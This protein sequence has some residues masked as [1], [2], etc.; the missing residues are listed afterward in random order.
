MHYTYSMANSQDKSSSGK[1]S[2]HIGH[3]DINASSFES[4]PAT[5]GLP[6]LVTRN[7]V[8]FPG[9]SLPLVLVRDESLFLAREAERLHIP[10]GV[11]NQL[12][13]DNEEVNSISEVFDYGVFAHVL[14]VLE[15]PDDT[16][17]ALLKAGTR[18][19]ITG[20]GNKEVIPMAALHAHVV[21]ATET[22]SHDQ[23]MM[24][25]LA[26]NI[27]DC[28]Q[29]I[30]EA[31]SNDGAEF[32]SNLDNYT[33]PDEIINFVCTTAPVDIEDKRELL[34]RR[35]LMKRGTQLL[36]LLQ[37]LQSQH[38]MRRELFE[39]TKTEMDAHQREAFLR[40]EMELISNQLYGDADDLGQ[41]QK[42]LEES[43]LPDSIRKSLEREMTRLKRFNPQSPDF[44]VLYGYIETVLDIPWNKASETI[45][46]YNT[47]AEVLEADHY[48]LTKVKERILE[49][50]AV[51]VN[52]PDGRAPI[53]CL[54]GPPGVGKTSLGRSVARAL[55]REYA[56]VSLGGLHDE[57]EIRGH[58]RTYIGA[59]PGR[60]I[61]AL[62]K[63]GTNNPVIVLDEIDKIGKDYK[64]DPDAAL[65]EV[66]DPEQNKYF[67]DNYI[68]LDVDLS[69]VVFIATAN[70]L[71][72]ISAPLL[73]RMEIID[74]S[75]YVV[76]E[77]MEIAKRHLLPEILKELGY[78]GPELKISDKSLQALIERYTSESGVRA[79]KKMLQKTVRRAIVAAV[80][81]DKTFPSV[82][83]PEDLYGILGKEPYNPDSYEGNDIPGVVNGLAWTAAGG[84]L[85]LVEASLSPGKPEQ[86]HVTGNLGDVMKESAAISLQWVKANAE[87]CGID[88][89]VL[90]TKSVHVHFPEGAI[91]KDGPS[92]GIT[93][94]TAIVSALTGRKLKPRTAM[95]GE[96]SLRGRVL[97]VGGI[98]EKL[99]AA[100]RAGIETVIMSERNRAD[101]R[102]ID[103][104]YTSGLNIIYVDTVNQVLEHALI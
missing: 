16:H 56:R 83:E 78:K 27:R 41:L 89:A 14:K 91:P 72:T 15:M 7:L 43:D 6:L 82:I 52:N 23:N 39:A 86:I 2:Y 66:L 98:K 31:M 61:A 102:E 54:V 62:K 77:K 20:E 51:L 74:L 103:E 71:S 3:I 80:R 60:I 81:G 12:N 97:P 65:L 10:V 40:Q 75:G 26:S 49:Q 1:T 58:R 37:S 68:D 87:L 35:S 33:T 5:D 93:M 64:G 79:L 29:S 22:D 59:M 4:K 13:Q 32:K 11:V 104:A 8:L 99:L 53:L 17:L 92:A 25:A 46:E 67:H 88:R 28:A 42:R 90:D 84:T 57:A 48:G 69:K 55:G 34:S 38:N 19:R 70:S 94:V 18:F 50:I 63:A 30:I 76:E 47:A 24:Q 100:R 36:V 95:T 96:M 73:D 45:P 85:L 9:V 44:S 21:R 101:V